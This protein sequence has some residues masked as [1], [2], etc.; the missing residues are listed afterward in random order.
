MQ[1]L[2]LL[3]WFCLVTG[4]AT[5][6]G[7]SLETKRPAKASQQATRPV[8][9]VPSAAAEEPIEDRPARPDPF[10]FLQR[11]GDVHWIVADR[12]GHLRCAAFVVTPY[13]P[14]G[15]GRIRP[16]EPE[17]GILYAVAHIKGEPPPPP[18]PPPD[19]FRRVEFEFELASDSVVLHSPRGATATEWALLSPCRS[20]YSAE[21]LPWFE[22]AEHCEAALP[23]SKPLDLG[24]CAGVLDYPFEDTGPDWLGRRLESGGHAFELAD[25]KDQRRCVSWTFRPSNR[26][27]EGRMT[28]SRTDGSRT[29]VTSFGYSLGGKTL[30]LLGPSHRTLEHGREVSFMGYG[31]GETYLLHR[32]DADQATVGGVRWFSTLGACEKASQEVASP[33]TEAHRSTCSP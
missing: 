5:G 16:K 7:S 25:Q 2:R 17:M 22:S 4:T 18:P 3:S 8:A 24:A 14:K 15:T 23:S 27:G 12:A 28:S 9:A 20:T 11:E 26:K 33:S 30:I 10:A 21:D 29:V 32:I 1:T 31:C 19:P 13:S 6:C